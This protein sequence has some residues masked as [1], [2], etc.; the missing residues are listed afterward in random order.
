MSYTLYSIASAQVGSQLSVPRDWFGDTF[1]GHQLKV[2]LC[3]VCLSVCPLFCPSFNIT[4]TLILC[5]VHR[6]LISKRL[7]PQSCLASSIYITMCTTSLLI[8]HI[9]IFNYV[10]CSISLLIEKNRVD[11]SWLVIIMLIIIVV[12]CGYD[13]RLRRW[14]GEKVDGEGWN[15]TVLLSYY[16]IAFTFKD[17]PCA[18]W[19][20]T[21]W[22]LE[23]GPGKY[24]Q[25]PY[26]H[27]LQQLQHKTN[28]CRRITSLSLSL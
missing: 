9:S 26:K 15:I 27:V 13:A 21:T 24:L 6:T 12:S 3:P 18:Q 1:R 8:I 17:T 2:L 25:L 23:L 19:P 28:N 10:R 11:N 4:I 5:V 20:P 7:S 22:K 16:C 14:L